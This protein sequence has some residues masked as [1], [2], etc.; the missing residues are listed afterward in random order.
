MQVLRIS[1][2]LTLCGSNDHTTKFWCQNR[3]GDPSRDKHNNGSGDLDAAAPGHFAGNFPV[4]DAPTTPGPFAAGLARSDGT[5]PGVGTAMPFA[6]SP[7]DGSDQGQQSHPIPVPGQHQHHPLQPPM[8][9]LPPITL[10]QLQPPSQLPLLAHPS[11]FPR[12]PPTQFPSLSVPAST[13]SSNALSMPMQSMS[14]SLPLPMPGSAFDS[15]LPRPTSL[16]SNN[17]PPVLAMTGQGLQSSATQIPQLPQPPL[18][19]NQIIAGP[20]AGSSVPPAI[21]VFHQALL[22]G[23]H[24]L[25]V[26]SSPAPNLDY[27]HLFQGLAPTRQ[28]FQE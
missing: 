9:P 13:P 24:L 20:M 28:E 12:P 21:H 1:W 11:H 15:M 14:D 19:M 25:L 27:W 18:G 17:Y 6:M 2:G 26:V 3:P 16:Q 7:L 4:P 23:R 5:I 10:P 22:Q 8:M